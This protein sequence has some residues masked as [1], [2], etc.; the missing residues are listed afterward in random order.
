MKPTTRNWIKRI[1]HKAAWIM[2]IST[3]NSCV[4]MSWFS[5]LVLLN[6]VGLLVKL[7]YIAWVNALGAQVFMFQT[8]H[9]TRHKKLNAISML[10]S[11]LFN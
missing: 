9:K 1:L 11:T 6:S 7:G 3:L 5:Y 4:G 8:C 10:H 2:V